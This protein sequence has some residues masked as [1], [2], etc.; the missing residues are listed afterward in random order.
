MTTELLD[1]P[2]LTVTCKE[3]KETFEREVRLTKLTVERLGYL[4]EKLQPFD[5]L[6]NDF[7]DGDFEAFVGHFLL[8]INGEIRPAGLMWDV[9]DVGMIFLNELKPGL[10]AT[11]HFCFWDRRFKGRENLLKG[12]LKHAFETYDFRRIEV[13][14]PHYASKTLHAVQSLGFTSEGILR[15]AALYKG[16]WYNVTILSMLWDEL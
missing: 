9:D 14:V 16:E 4:W 13:R 8:N 12:M 7:V 10:S 3:K 5:T 15:E 2:I 6:F 1:P 11:A